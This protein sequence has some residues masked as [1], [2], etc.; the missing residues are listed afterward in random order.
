M[1]LLSCLGDDEAVVGVEVAKANG[2]EPFLARIV[3]QS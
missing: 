1:T 3:H 2:R